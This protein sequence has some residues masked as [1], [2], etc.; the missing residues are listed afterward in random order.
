MGTLSGANPLLAPGIMAL[1]AALAIAA[2]YYH[3]SLRA[4]ERAEGRA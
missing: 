3:P 1:T 4:N 2:T